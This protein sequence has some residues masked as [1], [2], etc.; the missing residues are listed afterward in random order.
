MP[1]YTIRCQSCGTETD[2]YRTVA[3]YDDLPEH[4]G[5]RMVRA[6]TAPYVIGDINPYRSMATG[7]YVMGRAQHRDHLKRHGLIEIGNEKQ[8]KAKPEVGIGLKRDIADVMNGMG[9]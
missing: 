8:T 2:I 1:I 7:E 4:C 6:V 9:I 3:K 5:S